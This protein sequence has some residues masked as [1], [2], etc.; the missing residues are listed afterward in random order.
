MECTKYTLTR[1]PTEKKRETEMHERLREQDFIALGLGRI[2]ISSPLR[3]PLSYYLSHILTSYNSFITFV[4][5]PLLPT[6]CCSTSEP[7]HCL[8]SLR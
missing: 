7:F 3:L 2:L 1:V 6:L 5:Y 8:Y 4:I